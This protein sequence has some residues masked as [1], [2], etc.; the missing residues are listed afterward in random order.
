[1][2]K[3]DQNENSTPESH[4]SLSDAALLARLA[5]GSLPPALFDHEAH[6]RLAWLQLREVGSEAAPQQVCETIAGYVQHLGAHEKYHHTLS[7]AAVKAVDH[8]LQKSQ[9]STFQDFLLENPQLCTSFKALVN[10]HY[11]FDIFKSAQAKKEYIAPDLQ[12]FG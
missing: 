6:L 8:F 9:T 12:P 11:S 4:T 5:D 10:S 7:I 3:H 1:M 2:H